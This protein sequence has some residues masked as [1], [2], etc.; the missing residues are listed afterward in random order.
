MTT[1][2]RPTS[3]NNARWYSQTGEPCFEIIG[4]TTGKPRPVNIKDAREKNLVPSVTTI[5]NILAK[6]ELQNWLIEQAVLAVVTTPRQP[7]EA[8]DA[9][10][11]RVLHVEKVQDQEAAG[12]RD[13][14]SAIHDAMEAYFTGQDVSP[15]MRPWIEPAAKVICSYG[16]LVCCEKVL[17]GHGYAGRT[18]LILD[19]DD[20]W[21]IWDWKSTRSLP[22]KGAWNDHKLQAA[23][24]AGAYLHMLER[25]GAKKKIRTGN[26]YISTV[27]Q[28]KFVI[29]EHEGDWEQTYTKAW[30]PL[31][32][33]WKYLNN[34]GS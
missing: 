6:P 11:H 28:G 27:E 3:R 30:L 13:K 2:A 16:K 14:G 7:G 29:A 15:D 32:E 17:V 12:A 10:I 9:F 20:C 21:W 5:L 25:A 4:K 26:C 19:C 18:D 23:A 8:D 33:V 34:Y 24:Y 22:T 1:I 31:V